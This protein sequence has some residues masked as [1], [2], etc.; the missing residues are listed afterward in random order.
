MPLNLTRRT[1]ESLCFRVG[2]EEFFVVVDRIESGRAHLMIN[3]GRGVQVIRA[4]LLNPK[5]IRH[6][7]VKRSAS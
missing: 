1:G 7:G 3:A 5:E 6:G 4:E 2:N